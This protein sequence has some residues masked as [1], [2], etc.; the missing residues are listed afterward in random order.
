MMKRSGLETVRCTVSKCI[1]IDLLS[2]MREM[3]TFQKT[4]SVVG[5][6]KHG[7]KEKCQN[8]VD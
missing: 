8:V 4:I 6:S 5:L 2:G 1:A 7:N 3:M